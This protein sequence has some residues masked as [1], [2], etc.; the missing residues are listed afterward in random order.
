M[1]CMQREEN[2]RSK[3]GLNWLPDL[4]GLPSARHGWVGRKGHRGMVMGLS[5]LL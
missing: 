4:T 3:W 1:G 2:Q 5:A